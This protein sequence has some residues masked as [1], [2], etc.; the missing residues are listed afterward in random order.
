FAVIANDGKFIQ[1][2]V[3]DYIYDRNEDRKFIIK[4]KRETKV[5]KKE[6]ADIMTEML[7]KATEEGLGK[8]G[9][10][11]KYRVA[12]KTG[13]AQIPENGEYNPTKTN[14]TFV[15][16]LATNKE[17]A[18]I[19]KF[20]E[21]KTSI[22]ANGNAVPTWFKIAEALTGYFGIKPDY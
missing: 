17:F 19:V 18:M 20:E 3:V 2:T 22:Y 5:I 16:Y 12:A 14:T 10:L 4:E 7:V 6:T 8:T 9:F 11:T 1:P 15:G 13:T 21:P